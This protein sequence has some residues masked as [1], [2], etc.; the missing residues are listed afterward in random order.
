[1]FLSI[2]LLVFQTNSS[3]SQYKKIH[4]QQIWDQLPKLIH[5][6]SL[7]SSIVAFGRNLKTFYKTTLSKL[8]TLNTK[9]CRVLL[10]APLKSCLI[11]RLGKYM[12]PSRSDF[13]SIDQLE[14]Y[15]VPIRFNF[16]S[17]DRLLQ[18]YVVPALD[19]TFFLSL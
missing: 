2:C 3:G 1:M 15:M 8:S 9:I 13:D 10:A 6:A 16:D 17:L 7:F 14:K 11:D 18:I 19:S 4:H 12:V 5:E